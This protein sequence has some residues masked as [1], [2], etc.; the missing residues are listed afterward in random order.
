MSSNCH[1]KNKT[2]EY[3]SFTIRGVCDPTIYIMHTLVVSGSQTAVKDPASLLHPQCFFVV[4][5]IWEIRV[6]CD[7]FQYS[8]MPGCSLPVIFL[9]VVRNLF[10]ISIYS[11]SYLFI[12]H[13]I[14]SMH[15]CIC[16]TPAKQLLLCIRHTF[17]QC[18]IFC[19]LNHLLL[20]LYLMFL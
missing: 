19:S 13:N 20:L 14:N 5:T 18:C 7:I 9:I 4:L 15:L 10:F 11:V 2:P 8:Q 1:Q 6:F 16:D 3:A 17:F 12:V